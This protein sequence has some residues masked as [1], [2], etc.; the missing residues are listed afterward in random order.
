MPPNK[1]FLYVIENHAW[2]CWYKLGRTSDLQE[3][4]K[5]YNRCTPFVDFGFVYTS[6]TYDIITDVTHAA[7]ILLE[8]SSKTNLGWYF[9]PCNKIQKVVESLE[10]DWRY[11][12]SKA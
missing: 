3:T 8:N 5:M 9:I 6:S 11:N 4:L 1:E 10:L 2:P 7:N 12:E